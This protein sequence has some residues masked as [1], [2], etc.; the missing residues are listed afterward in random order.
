MCEGKF[1]EVKEWLCPGHQLLVRRMGAN[2]EGKEKKAFQIFSLAGGRQQRSQQRAAK[3]GFLPRGEKK[4]NRHSRLRRMSH[5]YKSETCCN[6][7]S[8]I[9]LLGA[10]RGG[11][12][13]TFLSGGHPYFTWVE[14]GER[15]NLL[16]KG[17]RK[18]F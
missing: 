4:K 9:F 11:G 8:R 3:K 7:G 10:N 14:T 6:R 17:H 1:R 18:L 16:K 5:S 2:K 15:A 12:R 13:A